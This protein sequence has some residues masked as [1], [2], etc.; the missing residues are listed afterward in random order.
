MSTCEKINSDFDNYQ[1]ELETKETKR[2]YHTVID[3][4]DS[5]YKIIDDISGSELSDEKY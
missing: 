5:F 3:V 4:D 2:K 1:R